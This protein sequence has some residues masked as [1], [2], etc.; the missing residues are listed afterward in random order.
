MTLRSVLVV[1][2]SCS[3][4]RELRHREKGEREREKGEAEREGGGRERDKR[5]GDRERH[6]D[7]GERD[8]RDRETVTVK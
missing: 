8:I 4:C 7:K 1:L 2:H 5:G 3:T 6:R